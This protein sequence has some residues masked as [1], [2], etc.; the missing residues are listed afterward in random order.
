MWVIKSPCTNFTNRNI[1]PWIPDFCHHCLSIRNIGVFLYFIRV[2]ILYSCQHWGKTWISNFIK[3]QSRYQNIRNVLSSPHGI[4]KIHQFQPWAHTIHVKWI[5]KERSFILFDKQL[6]GRNLQIIE[7]T[8][9]E[10]LSTLMWKYSIHSPS[11]ETHHWKLHFFL[12][13][14]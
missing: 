9:V 1:P 7:A 6:E 3:T 2:L 13:K 10:T 8:R 12:G 4:L 14:V 5:N 11:K